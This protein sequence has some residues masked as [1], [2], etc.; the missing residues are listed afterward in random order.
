VPHGQA[1]WRR[2]YASGT[3]HGSRA[4]NTAGH[5]TRSARIRVAIL[6]AA[7]G[8]HLE[9]IE[10]RFDEVAAP[11]MRTVTWQSHGSHWSFTLCF[12]QAKRTS[13]GWVRLASPF[14]ENLW[15]QNLCD[16]I[17]RPHSIAS[18]R[19]IHCRLGP[20]RRCQVRVSDQ[21]RFLEAA[22]DIRDTTKAGISHPC[23]SK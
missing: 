15:N 3:D 12:S 17:Y 14:A 6:E 13:G 1:I 4:S 10:R 16:R 18:P 20:W 5:R 11:L 21:L 9:G 7:T 22:R 23:I 19:P 2:S 8:S